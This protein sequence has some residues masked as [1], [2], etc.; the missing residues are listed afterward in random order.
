LVFYLINEAGVALVPFSAFG[1]EI[2]TLVQSFCRRFGND[3]IS[4]M[5]PKLENA[6]NNLK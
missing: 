6:L 4:T 5:M 2:R 3:E 1:E